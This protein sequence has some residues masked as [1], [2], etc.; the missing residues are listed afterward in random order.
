MCYDAGIYLFI[1]TVGK[2]GNRHRI[3]TTN[4]IGCNTQEE[5][6]Q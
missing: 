4:V 3:Q 1:F 5:A 2:P 6:L